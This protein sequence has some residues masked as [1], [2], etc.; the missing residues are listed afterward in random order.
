[1][2]RKPRCEVKSPLCRQTAVGKFTGT[3]KSD[4]VFRCCLACL[5][6]MR[7]NGLRIKQVR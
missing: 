6:L 7:T 2:K 5:A 4:P 3:R 1:M